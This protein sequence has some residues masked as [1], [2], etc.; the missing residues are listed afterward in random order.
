MDAINSASSPA[1]ILCDGIP[2]DARELF[3][4]EVR[5][6]RTPRILMPDNH[7]LGSMPARGYGLVGNKTHRHLDSRHS[8]VLDHPQNWMLARA[9]LDHGR[10]HKYGAIPE[11]AVHRPRHL[12]KNLLVELLSWGAFQQSC[13]GAVDMNLGRKSASPIRER[14]LW[15][16]VAHSLRVAEL[17]APVAGVS[18]LLLIKQ[19]AVAAR[20]VAPLGDEVAARFRKVIQRDSVVGLR[21]ML[22]GAM[23]PKL[24]VA[25][26]IPMQRI[27]HPRLDQPVVARSPQQSLD[28]GGA[29]E[30][31]ANMRCASRLGE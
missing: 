8:R 1:E 20:G 5:N 18:V 17:A 15:K 10:Q 11:N 13:V 27:S 12:R 3:T 23:M 28:R 2:I 14:N 6:L 29:E 25:P 24:I 9:A 22:A 16:S 31:A 26:C 21:R 7:K 4:N 19:D 30:L